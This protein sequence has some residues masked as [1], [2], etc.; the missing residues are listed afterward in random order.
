MDWNL[1]TKI[2][3]EV[4][5][6]N[7]SARVWEIFY[8]EPFLVKDMPARIRYAKEKGLKD[9]VLNSNGVVMTKDKARA[10]IEAGLD[11]LY[12]GIDAAS[13]EAYNRVRVGGDFNKAVS[14]V[15]AYRDL[16][17]EIGKPT[18]QLFVQFVVSESNENEVEDFKKF[19]SDAS[20]KIKIRPK[21]SWGGLIE[22]RNLVDN[23]TVERKPCY[24]IVKTIN[25]CADG[26]VA[27][28]T[29]DIHSRI[30]C[31]N[32]KDH[33]L[34]EIWDTTLDNYRK[35]HAQKRFNDLPKMCKDC[36]DWQSTYAEYF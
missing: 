26:E 20:V 15:L 19:W 9:V 24:W 23:D 13:P 4:A 6:N 28:C 2:I 27:F 21:V 33:S 36:R 18:Q 11:A 35:M 16:L 29:V 7:P 5:A 10:C 31:G 30:K 14:N 17:K 32:V 8:G 1:Y 3:D 12:V 25:I 34:K 22:A